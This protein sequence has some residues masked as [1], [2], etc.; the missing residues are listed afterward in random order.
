M[1]S[2]HFIQITKRDNIPCHLACS[3]YSVE[4]LSVARQDIET[5]TEQCNLGIMPE[6][7]T[8]LC[9]LGAVTP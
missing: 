7:D 5:E 6:C 8:V 1:C 2:E 9:V 4:T 3:H